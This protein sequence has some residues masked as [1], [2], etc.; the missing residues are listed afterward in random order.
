M[1]SSCKKSGA[2]LRGKVSK[3]QNIDSF[4]RGAQE[5][6]FLLFSFNF[7]QLLGQAPCFWFVTCCTFKNLALIYFAFSPDIFMLA[8]H[9]SLLSSC[10]CFRRRVLEIQKFSQVMLHS[11][12]FHG[13]VVVVVSILFCRM[14]M[15]PGASFP[16]LCTSE[17]FEVSL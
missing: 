15:S 16:T 4:N 17:G 3:N 7:G 1:I 6:H 8:N 12:G 13:K 11:L 14:P 9:S 5:Y 2:I 10:C